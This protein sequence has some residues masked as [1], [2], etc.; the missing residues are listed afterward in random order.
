MNMK[1]G[2]TILTKKK[3]I[4]LE[5]IVYLIGQNVAMPPPLHRAWEI[6]V[7]KLVE[8]SIW[9][10][11]DLKAL[12]KVFFHFGQM[13]SKASKTKVILPLEELSPDGSK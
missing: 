6:V 7:G 10:K 3:E 1:S 11:D 9:D 4:N 8:P 13:V 5:G 2:T 12:A